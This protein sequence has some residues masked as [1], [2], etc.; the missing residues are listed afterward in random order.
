M[1]ELWERER[2]YFGIDSV[3]VA[4][5]KYLTSSLGDWEFI[6]NRSDTSAKHWSIKRSNQADRVYLIQ[7][8]IHPASK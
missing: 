4:R 1:F 2:A 5:M 8:S 3:K 6:L 7:S